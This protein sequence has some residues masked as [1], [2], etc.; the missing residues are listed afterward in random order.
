MVYSGLNAHNRRGFL[1]CLLSL[2]TLFERGLTCLPSAAPQA[3]YS[4]LL[5]GKL[6]QP[7]SAAKQYTLVLKNIDDEE[8][9]AAAILALRDS[10]APVDGRDSGSG[11]LLQPGVSAHRRARRPRLAIADVAVALPP[12]P[13]DTEA[14]SESALQ[15]IAVSLT[16]LPEGCPSRIPG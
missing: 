15:P 16:V 9:T 2:P 4:L 1:Q 13:S 12:A 6:V 8:A 3:F 7:G 10:D 5:K 11:D 14:S